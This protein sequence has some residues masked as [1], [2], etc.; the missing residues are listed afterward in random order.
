VSRWRY[1]WA[2]GHV[3]GIDVFRVE[4]TLVAEKAS[5]VKG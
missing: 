2:D 4:G 3:R 5:Y 1:D